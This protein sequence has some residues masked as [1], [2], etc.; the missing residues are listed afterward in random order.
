MTKLTK[1]FNTRLGSLLFLP[2]MLLIFIFALGQIVLP[3]LLY[4]LLVPHVGGLAAV[5]LTAV[6][7][8]L[9]VWLIQTRFSGS[10][11]PDH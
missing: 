4:R 10:S 2:F 8:G 5:G 3:V 1:F 9:Y 11:T 7:A 6:L